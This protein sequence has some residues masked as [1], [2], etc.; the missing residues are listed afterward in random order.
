MINVSVKMLNGDFLS[1]Q[2]KASRGFNDF[3]RTVYDECPNIPYG[4]LVLKRMNRENDENKD[5]K[6]EKQEKEEEKEIEDVRD[7]DELFAF[8]DTSRVRPVVELN[9]VVCIAHDKEAGKVEKVGKKEKKE[10]GE[11][12]EKKKKTEKTLLHFYIKFISFKAVDDLEDEY[13]YRSFFQSDVFYDQ[14]NRLFARK[15]TFQDPTPQEA[16][17]YFY[18]RKPGPY[19]PTSE[20][21]WFPTVKECLESVQNARFPQDEKTL[22]TIHEQIMEDLRHL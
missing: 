10:K 15:D 17:C 11:K 18:E 21:K 7:N 3:V 19:R 14:T 12:G 8:V 16:S 5:E 13:C 6:E 9:G 2:H 4:C 22:S 1:I 20:T